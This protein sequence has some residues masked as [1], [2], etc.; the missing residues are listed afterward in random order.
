MAPD[1]WETTLL[2]LSGQAPPGL[3]AKEVESGPIPSIA[4][5]IDP[6]VLVCVD[7]ELPGE[8]KQSSFSSAVCER[9]RAEPVAA[10]AA[11]GCNGVTGHKK[12]PTHR[13]RCRNNG[14]S[15]SG[16]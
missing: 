7:A 10:G 5:P 6:W 8:E 9:N 12:Q 16:P 13:C 14:R 11:S 4:F 15:A 2:N 3:K 1:R